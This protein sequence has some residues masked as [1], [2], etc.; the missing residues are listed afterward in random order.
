[1]SKLPSV[2]PNAHRSVTPHPHIVTASYGTLHAWGRVRFREGQS[3]PD[4]MKGVV[5]TWASLGDLWAFHAQFSRSR[6]ENGGLMVE[7]ID[8]IAGEAASVIDLIQWEPELPVDD[9]RCLW[10]GATLV[11]K[12]GRPSGVLYDT[13]VDSEDANKTEI[14][15]RSVLGASVDLGPE[16][17]TASTLG[18]GYPRECRRAILA[19]DLPALNGAS[20]ARAI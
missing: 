12:D 16:V 8:D 19:A 13:L 18:R 5:F 15:L 17:W 20:E 11:Y 4:S 6:V 9:E 3:R 7:V 14:A 1:M 2:Y 10:N